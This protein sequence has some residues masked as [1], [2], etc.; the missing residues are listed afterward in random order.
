MMI[1]YF[2]DGKTLKFINQHLSSGDF[3]IFMLYE[4]E[5]LQAFSKTQ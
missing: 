2:V 3:A 1:L 5:S 4:K